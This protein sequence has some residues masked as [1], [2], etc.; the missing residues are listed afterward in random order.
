MRA[1]PPLHRGAVVAGGITYNGR[2]L[3]GLDA[4]A[5]V[6]LGIVQVP[7]GRRV[8]GRLMVEENLK[9]G[10]LG[11]DPQQLIRRATSR[12]GSLLAPCPHASISG[13]RRCV[14]AMPMY[15]KDGDWTWDDL[16]DLPDEYRYEI[17]NGA[18]EVNALPT[19]WHEY[20]VAELHALLR[21]AAPS[22]LV[23]LGPVGVE[24]GRTYRGPD[25]LVVPERP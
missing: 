16:L 3:H 11:A 22:D 9:V 2:S 19:P 24:M 7:E 23:V 10:A 4:A 8:F 18:L 21:A 25:I 14:M 13:A 1:S 6:R 20:F 17:V 5:T 15:V 12:V